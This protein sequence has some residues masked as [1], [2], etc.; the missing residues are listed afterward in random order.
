MLQVQRLGAD[1]Q[2]AGVADQHVSQT[3]VCDMVTARRGRQPRGR[4]EPDRLRR[5]AEPRRR[6]RHAGVCRSGRPAAR[7]F[8]CEPDPGRRGQSRSRPAAAPEPLSGTEAPESSRPSCAPTHGSSTARPPSG[9]R[10]RRGSAAARSA[11]S[12]PPARPAWTNSARPSTRPRST[13]PQPWRSSAPR[14][15]IR[16]STGPAL[17]VARVDPLDQILAVANTHA[18]PFPASEAA[19]KRRTSS[20]SRDNAAAMASGSCPR[21]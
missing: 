16:I 6:D 15:A 10:R 9:T 17:A 21:P 2:D 5:R 7:E 3:N 12:P 20:T 11:R 14:R 8:G 13:A 18:D 19:S 1:L 4:E